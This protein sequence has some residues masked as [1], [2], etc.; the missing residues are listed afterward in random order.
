[1][2]RIAELP[3]PGEPLT[4]FSNAVFRNRPSTFEPY[5][6]NNRPILLRNDEIRPYN[7]L[8]RHA[9]E[10]AVWP[11]YSWDQNACGTRLAAIN[12]LRGA[13]VTAM[14]A[15]GFKVRDEAVLQVLVQDV[16]KSS[17][18]EGEMLDAGQVRSSIARKLGMDY[19]GLPEPDRK[20]DGVVAMMLDATQRFDVPRYEERVFGWHAALFPTGYSGLFKIP[21]ARWRDDSG[22]PM[23]VVSGPMGREKVRSRLS[24]RNRHFGTPLETSSLTS[25]KSS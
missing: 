22:G 3:W 17:E 21:V 25:A 10:L 2:S 23:Q 20:T 12:F 14:A 4:Q 15:I 8:M 18:I 9:H 19:A 13:L 5:E 24:A 11:N 6:E 7:L 1:M 16:V